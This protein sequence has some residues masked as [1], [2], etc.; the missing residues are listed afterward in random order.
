LENEIRYLKNVRI[1]QD[2]LLNLFDLY[3]DTVQFSWSNQKV[4]R[5]L[6]HNVCGPD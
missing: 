1:I 5:K 3:V 6:S 2:G 4:V